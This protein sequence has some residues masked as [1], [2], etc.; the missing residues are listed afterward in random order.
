MTNN[1]KKVFI[2]FNDEIT[3]CLI[4]CEHCGNCC[5]GTT[6][7]AI[8]LLDTDIERIEKY[9]KKPI[10]AMLC[11]T[12]HNDKEFSALKHPCPFYKYGCT[13]YTVRPL[14]CRQYPVRYFDGEIQVDYTTCPAATRTYDR[15]FEEYSDSL[16]KNFRKK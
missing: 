4:D 13:I 5:N 7:T 1:Y 16:E 14:S 12:T 2:H 10:T 9:L 15:L 11:K 6:F 3:K 8:V